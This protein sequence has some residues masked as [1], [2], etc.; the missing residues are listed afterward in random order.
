MVRL[1]P[2]DRREA[3]RRDLAAARGKFQGARRYARQQ[4][5]LAQFLLM[6]RRRAYAVSNHEAAH[7][8]RRARKR[9]PQDEVKQCE[10]RQKK[11]RSRARPP[12]AIVAYSIA[13]NN[14]PATYIL[15]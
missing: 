11:F 1:A 12:L 14:Q 15:R 7:P 10:I 9:A 6:V 3:Q 4:Q 13:R 8:S 2:A 5:Q